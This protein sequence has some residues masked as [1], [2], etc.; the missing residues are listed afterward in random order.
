MAPKRRPSAVAAAAET[1]SKLVLR[2]PAARA[3]DPKELCP[4][5]CEAEPCR[6]SHSEIGRRAGV[7]PSR[8]QSSCCFCA[9]DVLKK[10]L[11]TSQGKG[12]ITAALAFFH[13]NDD[14]IYA[15]ACNRITSFCSHEVLDQC[16]DR[17]KRLQKKGLTRASRARNAKQK[18]EQRRVAAAA[19]RID[20]W[21]ALLEK[22]KVQAQPTAENKEEF[23]QVQRA[24][25]RKLAQKL[26]AIYDQNQQ[27]PTS[28]WRSFLAE[29]FSRWACRASWIMCSECHRLEPHKFWPTHVRQ[30]K[31]HAAVTVK[32]KYCKSGVGYWAPQ[33]EDVPEPLRN[34]TD[35]ALEA[36][37][38]F[39]IYAG[40]A[41]RAHPGYWVHTGAIRFSWKTVS[42]EERLVA[43]PKA[44][45]KKA[46]KAYRYLLDKDSGSSYKDFLDLH[47]KFLRQRQRQ[48][49]SGD[50]DV[51]EP[52]QWLPMN[53]M[54]TVGLE[55]A[56][57]PHL[58]WCTEM[59]ET[60][61]RSQD[62]RRL[63][64]VQPQG[65]AMRGD[66]SDSEEAE[67]DAPGAEGS[68]RQSFKASFLAKVF[69]PVIGYGADWRLAQFVYD[70]W[71]W[72]SLGGA[73]HCGGASL[74]GA[75]AGRTFSPVYWQ[76]MHLALVDVVKQIGFPSLFIT[77]APFEPTAPYH[78]WLEDELQKTLRARTNLPAAE[79]FHLA[80]LLVQAAEGLICGTNKQDRSRRD[81]SWKE[82]VLGA[83]EETVVEIFGRLEFQ[84]GKRKR[85][86]GP[87]QNYHGSGRVHLHLLVW[88]KNLAAVDWAKVLRA[89]L[90]DEDE[91]ELR[92][93]VKDSQ[94]DYENSAW[95]VREGPTTYDRQS[96][97][98][99]LHHPADAKAKN[100]RA[101][102]P[103]VLTALQCH[104]DVQTAHGDGR[105]LLLQYVASYAV[106]FSDSFATAWLNEEA[107]AYHL[108]RK[109]LSEYHPLEPEM[110]M[111]LGAQQFRQVVATPV[112]RKLSVRTPWTGQEPTQWERMYMECP[113]REEDCTLLEFV[114]ASTKDGRQRSTRMGGGRRRVAVAAQ[115]NSRLKDAFY[116]QWLVL[117]VPFRDIDE[118]WSDRA[119]LVP[120][121]Y[122]CLTLCLLT[123]PGHWRRPLEVER[124]MQ[125]EGHREAHIQ[126]VL[127]MLAG[128]TA[129]IDAYL[130]G[131]LNLEDHPEPDLRTILAAPEFGFRGALDPEQ[132]AVV[133][134]IRDMVRWSMQRRYPDE[135]TT[136]DLR[137]F[138]DQPLEHAPRAGRPLCVLGPG[139]SGKSTSV[140]VAVQRAAEAGAH[141]GIACPTGML[142]SSYREK[143]PTLDVDTLHGMFALHKPENETWDLM[144]NFD[145]MVIDEVGQLSR[146][147]FE[148][149]MRL[150]DNAERCPSLVFVGD[151]HQ[152]RG[153]D[154]TRALDSPRWRQVVKRHLRTM[155][156][157]QCDEL[158]WKLQLLRTAKPS[159]EQLLQ[160]VRGHR[161]MPDR[162]PG[163]SPEPTTMDVKDILTETPNTTFVVITRRNAALLNDLAVT[164]IFGHADPVRVVPGDPESNTSNYRRGRLVD[165][166]PARVPIYIG[167]RI[168]L[169]RNIDKENHF[170]N[171]MSAEVVA[172]R[173]Q[174]VVVRTKVGNIVTV[175]PYTDDDLLVDGQPR[176]ATYLPLRLGYAVTLQKVQGATMDHVTIWLDVANVE[177][178]GYVALS[179]VRRDADW[180]FIGHVTPHH[181]TPASGV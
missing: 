162:G 51:A 15:V 36:L 65:P 64:R 159:R 122:R 111:Q 88:M 13:E 108:A 85:H 59:C 117:N 22:R 175:F 29:G 46:R 90:P 181:F 99:L 102:L 41:E 171:G 42:V 105:A 5:L 115:T 17:L 3:Y 142:A 150:W 176:R 104:M 134:N 120:Q 32:C 157:C 55:C 118:L 82:H 16:L 119:L 145:L 156:R 9:A 97:S 94:L 129:V 23:K 70:L 43:L 127:A 135:A 177:A 24:E 37:A 178:A 164:A 131:Q 174:C 180:R 179:R 44:D 6:F 11:K 98:V 140:E 33:L 21:V 169:T 84:D 71:L 92:D 143:F 61:V 110:W 60:Y 125:L 25:A 139:G 89:D 167:A 47:A 75:L 112:M 130:T 20:E 87:V 163:V 18:R 166:E 155:R 74:R 144:A 152:L 107:S 124:E 7:Q 73:K 54:E 158:R 165:C 147:T 100:V 93:L 56:L 114:R 132:A 27:R 10:H 113:W 79:S 126:N 160:L 149:V 173:Q 34:L 136:E 66:S 168:T 95:P 68:A 121:G 53:F 77:V 30:H 138:Q 123:R 154:P 103:D 40:P 45:W 8:G 153:M 39:D 12:S 62:S 26:P 78:S 19:P 148:R 83:R 101:Y 35:V 28:A 141:V 67:H 57:W 1:P 2:R 76:N 63:A 4:G 137:Q 172:V 109:I 170:V 146:I 133:E 81:R 72:S 49:E 38:M 14:D 48:L 116:G 80:H 50:V 58:Y 106:K 161:A 128:Y 151:F 69:S 52:V 86:V 91:P 96:N 31:K